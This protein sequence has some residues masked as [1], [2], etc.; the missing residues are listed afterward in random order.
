MLI[1]EVQACSPPSQRARDVRSQ[2][3]S[4]PIALV[5]S[6]VQI[7]PNAVG[8]LPMV[9]LLPRV[10]VYPRLDVGADSRAGY[11]TLRK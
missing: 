5:A 8:L 6:I 7:T 3:D 9:G 11:F 4:R 2:M 10:R 1:H